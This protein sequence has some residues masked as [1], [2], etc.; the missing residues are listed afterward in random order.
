MVSRIIDYT[1]EGDSKTGWE[2]SPS[3]SLTLVLTL[4]HAALSIRP[5]PLSPLHVIDQ[6]GLASAPDQYRRHPR[7]QPTALVIPLQILAQAAVSLRP[8]EGCFS[9]FS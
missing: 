8:R 6:S 3:F 7:L 1:R 2:A 5:V 4:A 9:G